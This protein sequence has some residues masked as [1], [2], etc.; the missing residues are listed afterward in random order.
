[1][2]GAPVLGQY[3]TSASVGSTWISLWRILSTVMKLALCG[4]KALFEDMTVPKDDEEADI[5]TTV[6]LAIYMTRISA[7]AECLS[8]ELGCFI[9]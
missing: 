7:P 1:V 8:T 4:L 6:E 3:V 5:G 2:G 9:S